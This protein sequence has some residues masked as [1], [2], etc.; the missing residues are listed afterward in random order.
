MVLGPR[1][2][3]GEVGTL[4]I[5]LGE[6]ARDIVQRLELRFALGCEHHFVAA[7]FDDDLGA[8]KTKSLGKPNG[9]AAAA[10]ENLGRSH[11]YTV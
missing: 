11:S 7:L 1:G 8:F 9:L 4:R 10:L 6:V 2:R 3:I 5:L